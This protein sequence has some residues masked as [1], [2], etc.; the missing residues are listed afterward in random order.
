M[1]ESGELDLEPADEDLLRAFP[2]IGKRYLVFAM[3]DGEDDGWIHA[4]ETW[5]ELVRRIRGLL[6]DEWGLIA[7]Y[8]L[9]LPDYMTPLDLNIT[10]KVRRRPVRR[11]N[12]ETR[13]RSPAP[14]PSGR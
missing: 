7:V 14:T 13:Q 11:P 9:D 5:E 3:T 12:A 4:D 8:D 2:D 6:F 10:V 1:E